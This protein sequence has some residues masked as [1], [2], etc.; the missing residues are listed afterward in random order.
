M[1][2]GWENRFLGN[3]LGIDVTY[4]NDKIVD[5]IMPLT[6]PATIGAS[7]VV[8]NV[9][10]MRNYGVEIGLS[11]T[12]V[13][14]KNLVWDTRLNLAF[15]RNKVVALMPGLDKLQF[16]SLDNNS[17][18]IVAQAG[19]A[20]GDIIG[21]KR[22]VDDK[23]NYIINSDGYY[24][25]NFD[26]QV[27]MGNL[28]SKAVGGFINTFNYKNFSL[29]VVVDFRF[30]GQVV[31]QA[32]LYGMGAGLY[33]NTMFGRDAEH[34][35]LPYYTDKNSGKNVQVA[36]NVA[37]GPNGERVFHDGVILKGV[38]ADGK[39]NATVLD[40]A[41]YYMNTFTWG[42]WPGSGSTSTYEAAVYNND[43]IKMRE[44]T[45]SY[46]LPHNI[47][48]KLKAQNFT[49]SVYGRNLFYFRKTLPYLDPEEGVGTNWISQGI[50]SGQGNA[51]TRSL[52]GSIRVS[53]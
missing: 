3:R 36:D 22:R 5:Q 6:T 9:G 38:T 13:K 24:D 19:K 2:F 52:G 31:S 39:A 50:T 42:S 45:L 27:K 30:G 37:S 33:K 53:F 15:N 32:L 43:Y 17:L 48:S 16:N 25:I 10:D 4:Y 1:E 51:A 8:V 7:S 35:G 47:A 49:I 23:G 11:G 34:G 29:N 44:V 12:P 26:Q 20:A 41:S 14:M 18:L 28:Q 46:T 40:A 21:Y